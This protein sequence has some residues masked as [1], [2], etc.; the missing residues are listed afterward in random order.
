MSIGN[1]GG[2]YT[3]IRNEALK[4]ADQ[5]GSRDKHIREKQG[6]NTLYFHDSK[7][8]RISSLLPWKIG[9]RNTKRQRGAQSVR[10]A[11]NNQFAHLKGKDG[12]PLRVGNLVFQNINKTKHWLFESKLE[13][14]VTASDFRDIDREIANVLESLVPE[15]DQRVEAKLTAKSMRRAAT[16]N[17]RA[18]VLPNLPSYKLEA[19]QFRVA[20]KADLMASGMPAWQA[21]REVKNFVQDLRAQGD[22]Y[23][24]ELGVTHEQLDAVS[25]RFKKAGIKPVFINEMR[26]M[27][28]V[29][30]MARHT[31]AQMKT[32]AKEI[33]QVAAN[34]GQNGPAAQ[35]MRLFAEYADD[36]LESLPGMSQQQST[37]EL[38][39]FI[40]IGR[41]L[42]GDLDGAGG[43]GANLSASLDR[44][45]GAANE[46][47][48]ST[49]PMAQRYN[50]A[51]RPNTT[52]PPML[53]RE[54]S[55]YQS[56]DP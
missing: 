28:N 20:L 25:E 52:P 32:A 19:Q 23:N 44:L 53:N 55:L 1:S 26:Q 3:T 10:L 35:N 37:R 46:R 27:L 34:L 31:H 4:Q 12:K 33:R 43:W 40:A 5:L 17:M 13:K 22:E 14:G 38:A 18:A 7:K 11:I 29:R 50:L 54:N 21:D 47:M 16:G 9:Q 41:E 15:G 36:L 24:I 30:P 49:L 6:G 45:L 42:Q 48:T 51:L 2:D 8:N 56:P 39:K